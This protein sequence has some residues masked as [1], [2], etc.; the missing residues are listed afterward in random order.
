MARRAA[1]VV[2]LV[3]DG[4]GAGA[5][6]D[7]A[8]YG[9]EGADT[10]G[11]VAAATGGLSL[12]VLEAMGIG[13][14][15]SV[16]GVRGRRDTVGA[17]GRM[18][19]A[20]PG[21]DST[22][23]HWELAGVILQKPFPLYPRGFPSDLVER[24]EGLIG[25]KVLGNR[26]ASGTKIIEELGE[27]HLRSGSPILYTSADSVFQLAAHKDVIPLE[28]L[29]D[30]C[31]KAREMLQGEHAVCR[32]IARPFVGRPGSFRRIGAE[33]LDLS[34]PPPR[35]TVLDMC[36]SAGLPVKGVGKVGDL[37]A[38]RGFISSPHTEGNAE[39]MSRL[40][41]EVRAGGEGILMANLV[42]FDMLYGHRRDARGF[43]RALREV[44]DF[45][46]RLLRSMGEG[47]VLVVVSDHGCDPTFHGSDHTREYGILLLSGG[48][49]REGCDLGTRRTFADC[50]RTVADLLGLDAEGLDGESFAAE[51]CAG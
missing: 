50:G 38:G 15:T 51:A 30:M 27:E 4:V 46:P 8:D 11:H 2:W 1:R 28:E 7:A 22:T 5:L 47:D 45:L 24:F 44:N 10:L 16:R 3:L 39:T 42:D 20:S 36:S 48:M 17:Y 35:P 23:G 26:A 18:M 21:K 41:E 34:L 37:Y 6:P 9:D 49:V 33:R 19:E 12:P 14:L 31:R 29:Y 13:N 25:R 43:A 32:V 40:L